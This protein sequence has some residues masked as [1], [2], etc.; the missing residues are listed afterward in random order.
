MATTFSQVR[1]GDLIT[2]A[3]WN[4]VI[5]EINDLEV[6]VTKLETGVSSDGSVVITRVLPTG[7]LR[8]VTTEVHV[9]GRNFGFTAGACRV[10]VT[11]DSTSVRIDG[12]KLGTNDQELIFNIPAIPGV[13][14]SGTPARLSV[15]N[16]TTTDTADLTLLPAQSTL[17]GAVDVTP[18]GVDPATF[19]AGAQVDFKFNLKARTNMDAT[20]T[21]S[22]V[23]V[24][25][26]NQAAWQ[27]ALQVLDDTKAVLA[28]Q[29][30]QL[31]A[32]Q[33]KIVF[34]RITAVP[35]Q[36]ANAAFTLTLNVASGDVNNS[37]GPSAYTVGAASEQ[38][39]QT[40]T[41]F[42][43]SGVDPVSAWD[44]SGGE[45]TIKLGA[46][47]TADVTFL[48][49][50]T[51]A[52]IYEVSITPVAG[53]SNWTTTLNPDSTLPTFQIFPG[54]LANAQ[55]KAARNP[56]FLISPAAGASATGEVQFRLHRQNAATSRVYR[57]KLQLIS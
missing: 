31:T 41:A 6:R 57:M 46:G 19:N 7:A 13:L 40:I 29:S 33:E 42:S 9:Q 26:S 15:S 51:V 17:G 8:V 27:S 47:G 38:P 45:Q 52:A 25:A 10:F 54:D 28:Q 12:F 37:S 24:V 16:A 34:V 35:A 1:P 43:P 50:L 53:T 32:G 56:E 5:Q 48:A 30:L 11:V 14:S 21:L 20:F 36:P 55:Q 23:L 2:A 39:D 4:A 49:E 18:L 44:K 22:P 3:D